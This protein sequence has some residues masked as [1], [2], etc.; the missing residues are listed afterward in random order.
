M[1]LL[2]ELE[3]AIDADTH[4]AV[5]ESAIEGI[6]KHLIRTFVSDEPISRVVIDGLLTAHGYPEE[7]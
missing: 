7:N 2:E 1:L 4:R 5:A 3:H 6:R